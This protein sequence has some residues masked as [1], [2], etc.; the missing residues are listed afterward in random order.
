MRAATV[1][2]YGGPEVVAI[3]DQPAPVPRAGQILV[4]IRAASLNP[5]DSKLRSGALRRVMPLPLPAILGFDLAGEVEAVGPGVTGF[6]IG[7]RVYG[8]IDAK[9]GG[10]HAERAVIAARV[11]DRVPER[12]SFEQAAALPLTGMTAVQG[13]RLLQLRQGDRLL[14]NGAAGG[15]GVHAVQIGRA[16]GATVIGVASG[17]SAP[18]VTRLGA[19]RVLDYTRGELQATTERF[20]T[21]FDVMT[22]RPWPEMSRLL[23]S[24]G[25]YVTTGFSMNLALQYVLGR[26]TSRRRIHFVVSRADGALMRELSGFV[27][28]GELEPVIDSTWP[29]D[30]MREAYER[31]DAGHVHGKVVITVP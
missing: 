14:V 22:N 26:L 3:T 29:L 8:R 16:I 17:S 10:T 21:I 9:K 5:L 15:V 12:L 28:R 30:R 4:R 19:T 13:L 24:S 11:L 27:K 6:S 20:D 23:T 2:R 7:E 31:L 18:L 25:R 1:A